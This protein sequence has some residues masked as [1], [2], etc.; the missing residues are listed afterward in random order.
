MATKITIQ[1]GPYSASARILTAV[2]DETESEL[3]TVC[4][5]LPST[6]DIVDGVETVISHAHPAG[7][8]NS[9]YR[10]SACER[11]E[12]SYHPFPRGRENLDGTFTVLT[13][14]ELATAEVD[15]TVKKTL[16]FFACDRAQVEARSI[17][18]G[19]FYYVGP[20]R[21][22]K[23]YALVRDLMRDAPEDVAWITQWAYRSAPITVRAVFVG[24]LLAIQQLAGP[25][26]VVA[27]PALDLPSYNPAY[28]AH[29]VE[30]IDT[31][32]VEFDPHTFVDTRKTKIAEML[33]NAA[34]IVPIA[35]AASTSVDASS[36]A[37]L[38]SLESWAKEHKAAR[39]PVTV[40]PARRRKAPVAKVTEIAAPRK[41]PA[42]KA[43][44]QKVSA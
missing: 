23:F 32:R 27:P 44:Q 5:G 8:V 25:E 30:V 29:A 35:H 6:V 43:A 12:R 39:K 16:T 18:N 42:K 28:L 31:L 26:T 17:P 11:E 9:L 34:S 22:P 19:K 3:K 36:D 7:K 20:D 38:T 2:R 21:D 41:R 24:D 14:D 15:D 1:I 13:T 40:K 10:C 37:L 4:E 33:A